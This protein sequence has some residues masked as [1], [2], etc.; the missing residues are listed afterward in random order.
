[1]Q[2]ADTLLDTVLIKPGEYKNHTLFSMAPSLCNSW[3]LKE[4]DTTERLNWTELN[5]KMETGKQK[6]TRMQ[7]Q[8]MFFVEKHNT[9]MVLRYILRDI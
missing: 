3:G 5:W 2:I 1:M 8:G 4:P 6:T 7:N 9:C